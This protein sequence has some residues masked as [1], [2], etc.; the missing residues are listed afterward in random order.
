MSKPILKDLISSHNLVTLLNEQ[1]EKIAKKGYYHRGGFFIKRSLRPSEYITIFKENIYILRL[2]RERLQN[3]VESLRFIRYISNIPIL[4][5]YSLFKV[6]SSYFLVIE[7]IDGVSISQFL[8][9]Q[10]KL[11]QPKLNQYLISLYKIRSHKIGGPSRVM[12]PLYQV[13]DCIDNNS[14][15]QKLAKSLEY[16]FYYNNLSQ[17]NIIVDLEILKINTIIDQE[18]VSF[19]S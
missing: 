7:Y 6:D 1:S 19:F 5:I 4:T 10:K 11:I 2:G 14:Q 3:E 18:Y 8:E 17:Y 16:I 9:D 15:P 13:I 12:I